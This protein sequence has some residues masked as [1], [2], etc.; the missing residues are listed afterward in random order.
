MAA[1]APKSVSFTA[2][3]PE[4][5]ATWRATSLGAV[6]ESMEQALMIKLIGDLSGCRVLDVGCGDG[7]LC[8][9]LS[10]RGAD[11][12]GIDP[13][14]RMLEVA[15]RRARIDGQGAH[16]VAG[17]IE[18]IPFSN[19]SFDVVVA[20][21]VLCFVNDAQTAVRE[22][23]RVLRPGGELVLGELGRWN[24][25]AAMRRLRG[26][27]GAPIWRTARF[28]DSG[29]LLSLVAEAGL[30]VESMR[31]AVFYPPI[32]MLARR[33]TRLDRLLGGLTTFGAAF[34]ALRARRADSNLTTPP[35]SIPLV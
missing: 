9:A 22:M 28:R 5:Y 35:R 20:A 16:Y 10:L 18:R 25:W 34:I 33:L 6:T 30:A 4:A 1:Q 11:V 13:D 32:G 31:G 17:C 24:L 14:V 23:A 7:V 27:L 15:R 2:I 8:S 21:T 19:A 12:V 29:E 26:W 3:G